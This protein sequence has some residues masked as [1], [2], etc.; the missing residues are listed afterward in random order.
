MNREGAETYLRL[1]AE[2]ELRDLATVTSR[3]PSSAGRPFPLLPARIM[4]VAWALSAV[5]ALDPDSAEAIM[6]DVEL[7]MAVRQRPE[8]SGPGRTQYA[9]PAGPVGVAGPGGLGGP[10]GPGVAGGPG[11]PGGSRPG[12]WGFTGGLGSGSMIRLER[13]MGPAAADLPEPAAPGEPD[14]CVRL[15]LVIWFHDETVSGEL[16]LMSYAHT[17]AGGARFTSIW[18]TR[19]PLGSR[20]PGLPP[21]GAFTV[22][23]DRGSRYQLEFLNNGRP[24]ATCDLMLRPEPPRDIRWLDITAPGEQPVRVSLD[25]RGPGSPGGGQGP[26]GERS[27]GAGPGGQSVPEVLQVSRSPGEHLLTRLAEQLLMRAADLP[28][29]LWEQMSATSA[30]PFSEFATGLGEMI[31]ALE[32]AEVLSPLSPL[33]GQLATLCASLCVSGHGITAPPV[34]VLPEPWLSLLAHYHRRK[35]DTRPARD[36]WAA[37]AAVLPELDGLRLV[38][39]GLHNADGATWIH[40]LAAG[41][42]ERGGPSGPLGPGTR[43]PLSVWVHDSGGRWHIARPSGLATAE[44]EYG[45]TLR[46]LPPLLPS[47]V[48]IEL[49]AASQ[50]A[51]VRLTLPVRWGS[52]P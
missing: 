7:A 36:D 43:L 24:D 50:S 33:P 45:F 1:L 29:D 32:A 15:G 46:L 4:R 39:L 28:H 51:G 11:G 18:H 23:D 9:R 40:G 27:G 41:R 26:G 16:G 21:V 31:T 17:A 25:Q 42:I 19:D 22:T 13:L 49:L 2:A 14:R 34:P 5:H 6:G 20:R 44:G 35:P 12:R 30:G 47:T 8:V 10:A 48:W 52:P 3:A 37:I 38:L